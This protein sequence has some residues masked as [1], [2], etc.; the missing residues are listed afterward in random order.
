MTSTNQEYIPPRLQEIIEDFEFCDDREKVELLLDFAERMPPLPDWLQADLSSM[1]FVEEC[2]TPVYVKAEHHNSKM[3]FYF[4]VPAESP[5]VR[6]FAAIMAEGFEGATP[7]EVIR[8]PN[9][10]YFRMGLERILTMQ[11][12]NGIS[13]ILAHMKRLAVAALESSQ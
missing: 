2:M 5:T 4:E 1:D 8:V 7:E 3:K 13:A 12:L 11:R 6:G 10:F 9:D